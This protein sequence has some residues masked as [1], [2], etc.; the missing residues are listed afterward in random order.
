MEE[1]FGGK[2]VQGLMV[3]GIGNLAHMDNEIAK[4]VKTVC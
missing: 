1:I 2:E 4:N 3:Q